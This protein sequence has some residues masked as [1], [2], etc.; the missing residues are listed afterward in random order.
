MAGSMNSYFT[1]M[2]RQMHIEIL[3]RVSF[4]KDDSLALAKLVGSA[5][6]PRRVPAGQWPSRGA[7]NLYERGPRRSE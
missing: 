2:L 4:Y 1:E 3:F 5:L 7:N 6:R